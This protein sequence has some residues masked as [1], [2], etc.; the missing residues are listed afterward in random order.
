VRT[1][2][3]DGSS[4]IACSRNRCLAMDISLVPLF[5]LSGFMSQYVQRNYEYDDNNNKFIIMIIILS[6][7]R[8]KGKA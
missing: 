2:F 4:I 1:L 5:Q 8:S 6:A 3:G 7:R